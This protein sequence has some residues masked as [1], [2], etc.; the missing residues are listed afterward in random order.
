MNF[1]TKIAAALI[2]VWAVAGTAIYFARKA[3]PTAASVTAMVQ[4]FEAGAKVGASR[5]QE[6][7]RIGD[8]INRLPFDERQQLQR[9][10]TTRK[11]FESLSPEEQVGFLD[12]TLPSGFK[13]LMEA[14]NKME[15]ERRRKI[16]QRALDEMKKREGEETSRLPDEK[17]AQRIADVGLRSYYNDASAEVKL[18]LAPLIEQMQ[19]NLQGPR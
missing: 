16:V 7:A 8:A 17:V 10:G 3:K 13:Q 11:F 5:Q 9:S 12:A 18:D 1:W 15:P 4:G 14:F 6:L 19:K 2:V